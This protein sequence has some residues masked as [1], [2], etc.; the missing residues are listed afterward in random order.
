LSDDQ[1]K[2]ISEV[3]IDSKFS[4]LVFSGGDYFQYQIAKTIKEA[5]PRKRI[6]VIWHGSPLQLGP[7]YELDPFLAWISAARSGMCEAI[8][9]VKPGMTHLFEALNVRTHFLQNS[10]TSEPNFIE[11][12]SRAD[13]VGMWLSHVGNY[14]KP[15]APTLFALARSRHLS[16]QGSG[17][18][19]EGIQLIQRLR[20]PHKFITP[21]TVPHKRVLE[22][23][24]TS[25]L[26][27][28]ITL[29][30]CMPMVPFESIGEGAPCLVGPATQLY[31]DP[32]LEDHLMV[33][34]PFDPVEISKKVEGAMERY[35]ELLKASTDFLLRAKKR[36]AQDLTEFLA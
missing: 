13:V 31:D 18:S 22:G 20:I 26:T 24:R 21:S 4:Q 19:E 23:M 8:A 3:L 10:V 15:T 1:I 36:S 12:N 14:R 7:H 9:T 34:D 33:R 6:K 2:A 17:F 30:E 32:F 11:D 29:S 5:A 35:G 27:I 28:Y 16:L 25:K